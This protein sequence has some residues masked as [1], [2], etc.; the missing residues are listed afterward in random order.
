MHVL[1]SVWLCAFISAGAH[2]PKEWQIPCNKAVVPLLTE[3]VGTE[4]GSTL[5]GTLNHLAISPTPT[6]LLV[7]VILPVSGMNKILPNIINELDKINSSV[8]SFKIATKET[9]NV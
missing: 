9:P 8:G 1:V 5:Q 4:L 3:T 2:S 7:F 6:E